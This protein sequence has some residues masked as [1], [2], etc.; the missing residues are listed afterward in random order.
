M[1]WHQRGSGEIDAETLTPDGHR[2]I[3]AEINVA[4]QVIIL[5]ADVAFDAA[6]I[7]KTGGLYSLIILGIV[8]CDEINMRFFSF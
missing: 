1:R 3:F 7:D 2:A 8:C 6:E 4:R 5:I